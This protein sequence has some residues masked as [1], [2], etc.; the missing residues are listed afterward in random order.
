VVNVGLEGH[1]N[2]RIRWDDLA[3]A[4]GYWRGIDPQH[5]LMARVRS[6][7]GGM[8]VVRAT[9]AATSMAFDP[10]GRVR[11]SMSAWERNDRVMLATVPATQLPTLYT[12][13]GDWPALLAAA[14]ALAAAAAA[15][16]PARNLTPGTR[17]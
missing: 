8:S 1:R 17:T 7:E 6:I 16:L 14:L 15:F 9:R 10:H 4:G 5:T 11:A 2:G 3:L 12:S 13:A